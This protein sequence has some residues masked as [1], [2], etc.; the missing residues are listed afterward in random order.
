MFI[1]FESLREKLIRGMR[2]LRLGASRDT[3]CVH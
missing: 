1:M 3:I 2:V